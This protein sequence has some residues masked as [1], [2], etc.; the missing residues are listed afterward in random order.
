LVKL[1]QRSAG[2]LESRIKRCRV[3]GFPCYDHIPQRRYE[4]VVRVHAANDVLGVGV[5]YFDAN[6]FVAV[7]N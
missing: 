6:P 5:R 7:V 4:G 1:G 2:A 3:P